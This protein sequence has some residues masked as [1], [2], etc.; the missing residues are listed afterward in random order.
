M[1]TKT[2]KV[3]EKKATEPFPAKASGTD[4]NGLRWEEV[5]I[6][7]TVYRVREITVQESDDAYDVSLNDDKT[8]N[9]RLNQRMELVAAIEAPS[10][11]VDD[12]ANWG[13]LKLRALIYVFDRINNLPPAD[14]EGNA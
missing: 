1:V 5:P 12:I 13:T 6:F 8:F 11:S 3:E 9:A 14:T 4:A 10:T 2:T 7:G